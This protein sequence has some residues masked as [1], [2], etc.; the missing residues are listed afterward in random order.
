MYI[1][2]FF[3]YYSS[4]NK[5]ILYSKLFWFY[6]KQETDSAGIDVDIEA[7][8]KGRIKDGIEAGI[9]ASWYWSWHWNSY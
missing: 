8:L 2:V 3:T 7:Y 6:A 1:S 4:L 5:C 9:K